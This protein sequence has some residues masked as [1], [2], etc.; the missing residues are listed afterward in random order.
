MGQRSIPPRLISDIIIIRSHLPTPPPNPFVG[1]QEPATT[2]Y[3]CHGVFTAR[4]VFSL[5]LSRIQ[6]PTGTSVTNCNHKHRLVLTCRHVRV[7]PHC[8]ILND[9]NWPISRE[10]ISKNRLVCKNAFAMAYYGSCKLLVM[11]SWGRLLSA[12]N[13]P[14][15]IYKP[16]RRGAWREESVLPKPKHTDP[17]QDS[18]SDRMMI[19]RPSC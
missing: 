18:K 10:K 11:G 4:Y 12:F 8:F 1:R 5:N 19:W 14:L 7:R 16:G 15:P 17:G 3:S 2:P 9:W 13:S 6:I